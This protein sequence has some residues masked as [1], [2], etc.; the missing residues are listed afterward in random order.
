MPTWSEKELDDLPKDLLRQ[1][2]GRVLGP[3]AVKLRGQRNFYKSHFAGQ[4][5]RA[6]KLAK[7]LADAR[8]ACRRM[9]EELSANT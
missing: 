9:R 2:S 8:E 6:E 5:R 1:L 4:K 7:E 3:Y